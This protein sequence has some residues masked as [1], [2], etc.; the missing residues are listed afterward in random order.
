MRLSIFFLLLLPAVGIA[1]RDRGTTDPDPAKVRALLPEWRT[2]CEEHNDGLSC[3]NLGALYALGKVVEQSD[4]KAY[5]YYERACRFGQGARCLRAGV[6]VLNGKGAGQSVEKAGELFASGCRFLEPDACVNYYAVSH[7][8]TIQWTGET[9]EMPAGLKPIQ[10]DPAALTNVVSVLTIACTKSIGKACGNLGGIFEE[11][12]A[13]PRDLARALEFYQKACELGEAERCARAGRFVANGVPVVSPSKEK[14]AKLFD[15]F[16]ELKKLTTCPL[17]HQARQGHPIEL[18]LASAPAQPAHSRPA[19]PFPP[20]SKPAA[21]T[22][23]MDAYERKHE[24]AKALIE[25]SN[26]RLRAEAPK[27]T[28]PYARYPTDRAIDAS[29]LAPDLQ[30]MVAQCNQGNGRSCGNAAAALVDDSGKPKLWPEIARQLLERACFLGR[31]QRCVDLASF[32]RHGW[33]TE[34]S[35]ERESAAIKEACRLGH[36]SSC[37][38][39]PAAK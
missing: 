8:K 11:G 18:T 7:G 38:P 35:P 6:M 19:S 37:N 14:A 27:N 33:G 15:K 29:A 16:C 39:V 22:E 30:A 34:K 3:G 10:G 36:K 5:E 17:A 26:E 21:S 24:K 2:A 9:V 25:A 32:H 4:A 31:A 13:T 20:M 1:D 28:P 12:D 23:G